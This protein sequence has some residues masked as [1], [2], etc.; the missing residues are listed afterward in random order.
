LPTNAICLALVRGLGKAIIITTSATTPPPRA[1]RF[2]GASLI[3]DHFGWQV[4]AV[5]E[6]SR[7]SAEPSSIISLVNDTPQIIRRGAGDVGLFE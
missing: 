1:E 6:G 4:D 2:H 7:V 5:I 3:H